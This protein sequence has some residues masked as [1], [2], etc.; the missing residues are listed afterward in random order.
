MFAA[1][2]T[3]SPLFI[4]GLDGGGLGAG[5][6]LGIEL[7]SGSTIPNSGGIDRLYLQF[8]EPVLG[9]DASSV[10]LLGA[11]TIDYAAGMS[12]AYDSASMRGLIE[13][14]RALAIDR[15]TL[16]ILVSEAVVDLALNALDGDN[17]NLAGGALDVRFNVL[18][19]DADNDGNVNG[20]DLPF[21]AA[22]F[23]KSIGNPEYDPRADWNSDGS[24]NG[25]DLPFFADNF[26]QSLTPT[27][28][29]TFDFNSLSMTLVNDE[30]LAPPLEE[31]D[32]DTFFDRVD[33]E[34]E[35]WWQVGEELG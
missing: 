29:E 27:G 2:S 22:S 24:V 3:W 23:N 10:R 35:W 34:L 1:S 11:T 28:T 9:F 8:S 30:L 14:S 6:G 17:D 16:Q 31:V 13:I 12:V 25:A 32:I 15:D 18:V 21:F 5:N 26:N 19:G 4:D 20:G 7:A 33:D